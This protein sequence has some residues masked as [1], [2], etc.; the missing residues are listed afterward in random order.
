MNLQLVFSLPI[1][2]YYSANPFIFPFSNFNVLSLSFFAL[3][4]M[5]SKQELQPF[6]F[7]RW[8]V[9]SLYQNL[10]ENRNFSRKSLPKLVATTCICV[11]R[12]E[13]SFQGVS[14]YLLKKMLHVS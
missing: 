7:V 12:A 1:C 9:S 8:Q 2:F 14:S 13:A 6:F 3:S 11:M 4:L 10:P 5:N